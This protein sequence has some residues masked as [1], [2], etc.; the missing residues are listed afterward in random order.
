MC[1][2]LVLLAAFLAGSAGA[3]EVTTLT[4]PKSERL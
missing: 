1:L 2:A 4:H 3:S